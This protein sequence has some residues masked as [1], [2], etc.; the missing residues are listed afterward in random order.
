VLPHFP[1]RLL[2]PLLSGA[3]V[4]LGCEP[5]RPP[6]FRVGLIGVM[7]GTTGR[8]SGF[9]ARRG[10]Q[11]A[12]AELNAAGGVL[13]GGRAHTVVLV[14]RETAPRP[15]AAAQ[16]ARGLINLDSVDV[17]VGPQMSSL[18]VTAG[19]VAEASLVPMITPLASSPLVTA[20]RQ[21][22]TRLAFVD[23]FQGEVL[24]RFA[25]ES[26]AI[27][28]VAL[29]SD[30]ASPYAREITRIFRQ[31]FEG[32]GGEIV[33][34]EEFDA[35]DPAD[36]RPQI[37]R[38]VS[39]RPDAILLPSFV[40]HDSAQI[41]IARELGFRGVFL[42]SDAWD[43]VTLSSRDDALGSIVVAN[44]DRR[45]SRPALTR[46]LATWNAQSEERPRATGAATYDAVHLLA[47]AASRAGVRSG[48]A[49]SDSLRTL[50]AYD[51]AFSD[52]IFRGTGDPVRGA[53]ILEICRDS[54]RVRALAP[55]P[56]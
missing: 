20:G 37:R 50:G 34:T 23:A 18:A 28:R 27:R 22:V 38:I 31:T 10:A 25:A 15:E 55:A 5:R 43:I 1:R 14:E 35:D 16:A 46:F 49:L 4:L 48:I 13:I 56:R 40:V 24:A 44:W 2:L 52:Y 17:I 6:E 41:R 33:R 54:T 36:Q 26:L 7:D 29:L 11:I 53:V 12:V 51:G 19:A 39:A 3:L 32:L 30:A 8:S 45:A 47:L 42:G 21:M 9:P